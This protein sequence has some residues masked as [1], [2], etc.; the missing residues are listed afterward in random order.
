MLI[1][2][3]TISMKALYT[4]P[5]GQ[6]PSGAT[7]TNDRRKKIYEIC[8]KHNILILE[9]MFSGDGLY[10]LFVSFERNAAFHFV[11]THI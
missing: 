10:C 2:S 8:C 4:I 1:L 5:T 11:L 9:G 6:N 3:L 7:I